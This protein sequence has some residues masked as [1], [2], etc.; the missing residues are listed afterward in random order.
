MDAFKKLI[1]NTQQND[2]KLVIEKNCCERLLNMVPG[3][4]NLS[5]LKEGALLIK[6]YFTTWPSF[7]KILYCTLDYEIMIMNILLFN[8]FYA[9]IRSSMVSIFLIYIIEKL[10]MN[11]RG[12]LGEE[13]IAKKTLVEKCFLI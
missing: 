3:N 10:I 12:S 7:A 8:V 11:L 2:K 6:D 5:S 9:M 4:A 1:Y 13:N